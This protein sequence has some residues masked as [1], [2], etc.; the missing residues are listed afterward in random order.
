MY[1]LFFKMLYLKNNPAKMIIE[2]FYIMEQQHIH[3]RFTRFHTKGELIFKILTYSN[4]VP[5]LYT[6]KN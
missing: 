1:K 3:F 4:K 5:K 6:S 2:W